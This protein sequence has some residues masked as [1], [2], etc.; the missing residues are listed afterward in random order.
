MLVELHCQRAELKRLNESLSQANAELDTANQEL[1][2]EKSRELASSTEASKRRTAELL[3]ADRRKDDFLAILAHE[4]RNP[5]APIRSAIEIL[6][7]RDRTT[8]CW[9]RC[10]R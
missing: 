6:Q 10:A 2:R 9:S 3:D 8:R 4:L 1:Q 5:L 7:R